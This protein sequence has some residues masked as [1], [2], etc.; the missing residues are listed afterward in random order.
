MEAAQKQHVVE[1]GLA[2]ARPML[3]VM[4]L[5]AVRR[6]PTTG[7]A[8][9]AIAHVQRQPQPFG[10]DALLPAN[11]DRQSVA[12]APSTPP[13]VTA[14]PARRACRQRRTALDEAATLADLAREHAS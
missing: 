12:F 8:A 7:K 14:D 6:D 13:G 5:R 9:E 3:V 4:R 2:A 10:N 1:L 11:V